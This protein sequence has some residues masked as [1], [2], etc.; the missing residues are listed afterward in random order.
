M[1]EFERVVMTAT[2]QRRRQEAYQATCY[3]LMMQVVLGNA[4]VE[5]L[6]AIVEGIDA[7][8]PYPIPE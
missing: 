7:A 3:P 5:Q 2:A 4:D 1:T 6:R 8:N